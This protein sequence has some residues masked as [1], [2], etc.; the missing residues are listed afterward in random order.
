MRKNATLIELLQKLLQDLAT[1]C[2]NID[3][4]LQDF[5]RYVWILQNFCKSCVFLQ[6]FCKSCVFLQNFC[7][8]CIQFGQI[9]LNVFVIAL[10]E[11]D[12]YVLKFRL[13]L[14]ENEKESFSRFRTTLFAPVLKYDRND[15]VTLDKNCFFLYFYSD[16][17]GHYKTY[18]FRKFL[19]TD[20]FKHVRLQNT[21]NRCEVHQILVLTVDY[22][23]F[24]VKCLNY[25]N[26]MCLK[27]VLFFA[28]SCKIL[29]KIAFS[30]RNTSLAKF[31]QEMKKCCKIVARILQNLF[32][33]WAR[34]MSRGQSRRVLRPTKLRKTIVKKQKDKKNQQRYNRF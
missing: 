33:L 16:K 23:G 15:K 6:N 19:I 27:I 29:T 26:V 1:E 17:L 9:F 34:E 11:S 5:A 10:K 18:D 22:A 25:Q 4:L 32:F 21:F 7:K 14:Y 8:S 24:L 30:A 2:I 13:F 12:T 28:R 3:K 31:L 20:A